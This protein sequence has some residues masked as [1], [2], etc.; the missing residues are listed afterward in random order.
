MLCYN[1]NKVACQQAR[2]ILSSGFAAD[3]GKMSLTQKL[4][5]FENLTILNSRVKTNAIHISLNFDEQ[6]KLNTEQL[7]QI[8]MAY[9]E[10]IGFGDQPYLVYQHLDAAHKHIHIATT[11]IKSDGS[12]IDTHGIGWKVSESARI[13][14]EKEFDL[15]PAK[16]RK[17]SNALG[18]KPAGIE[19]AVYG[20][21]PTKRAITNIVNAVIRT[22]S[23]TS[24]S[25]M[26]AILKQFNVMADRGGENTVMFQKN[27]LLYSII[28]EKGEKIGVPIKA[29]TV[30]GK[31]TLSNLEKAFKIGAENRKP[32]KEPLKASIEKIFGEYSSISKATFAAELARQNIQVVFRQNNQGFIYGITFI[33]NQNKTVFNGSDLGKAYSAKAI[34]ERLRVQDKLIKPEQKTYLKPPKQT[35]YLKKNR[36]DKM[37]IK[38]PSPTNYLKSLLGNSKPEYTPLIPRKKKK[39]KKGFTI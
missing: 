27:G 15:I 20:K 17:T 38:V 31:P 9:M 24:F 5:R 22:Y 25:E 2:L 23:F 26:N 1:E 39:R 30:Y 18:I 4:H 6:D 10:K 36:T 21:M 8:V 16:G 11:N 34:I 19:Q 35:H 14:L 28:N 33:D 7:Q 12:R 3:I 29:S 37:D 32:L 13:E